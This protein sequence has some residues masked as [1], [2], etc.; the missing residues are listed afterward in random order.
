MKAICPRCEQDYLERVELVAL[1]CRAVLCPECDALW[2]DEHQVGPATEGSYGVTWFDFETFMEERGHPA[3]HR[4]AAAR[5][6][7]PL[8]RDES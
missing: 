2:L 3:R 4:D 5:V 6:L 8:S 1:R 7:G